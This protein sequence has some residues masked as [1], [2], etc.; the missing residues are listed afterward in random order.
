MILD[1]AL[2]D[3]FFAHNAHYNTILHVTGLPD[4]P[5]ANQQGAR[6]FGVFLWLQSQ[7]G[8]AITIS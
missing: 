2:S 1:I 7:K 6:A 5:F 3:S 4:G 8:R